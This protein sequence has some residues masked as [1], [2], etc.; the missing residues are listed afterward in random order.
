[1]TIM[2][3][4]QRDETL[5]KSLFLAAADSVCPNPPEYPVC[6]LKKSVPILKKIIKEV[7]YNRKS[8]ELACKIMD[9]A[10]PCERYFSTISV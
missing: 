8:A 9:E 2:N 6:N 1:M 7:V 10:R 4:V 3:A 5:L